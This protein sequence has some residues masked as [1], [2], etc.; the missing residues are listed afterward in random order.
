MAFLACGTDLA[1]LE[2]HNVDPLV[3][4]SGEFGAV[5]PEC[6]CEVFEL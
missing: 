6:C 3:S 5:M 1:Y 2:A 4:D